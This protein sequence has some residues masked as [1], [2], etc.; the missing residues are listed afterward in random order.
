MPRLFDGSRFGVALLGGTVAILVVVVL[1]SLL[2]GG[3]W[4]P[5]G[6]VFGDVTAGMR[7]PLA[8]QPV[9][10]ERIDGPDVVTTRTDAHGHFS[11]TVPPGRYYIAKTIAACP[12]LGPCEPRREFFLGLE[13]FTIAA[14]QHVELHLGTCGDIWQCPR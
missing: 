10:F 9:I 5:R 2:L 4:P 11:A 14:G 3:Q 13:V 8:D 6:L 12:R 7:G 1:G